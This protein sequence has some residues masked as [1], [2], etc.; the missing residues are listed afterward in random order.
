MVS[1]ISL[2]GSTDFVAI[3]VD[4]I[5]PL[6]QSSSTVV[7]AVSRY[8]VIPDLLNCGSDELMKVLAIRRHTL[9]VLL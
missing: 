4:M 1:F 2:F 9:L 7:L 3:I 6:A 5:T 8:T